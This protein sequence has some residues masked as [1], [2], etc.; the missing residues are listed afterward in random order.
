MCQGQAAAKRWRGDGSR[1]APTGRM[2][3]PYQER[4]GPEADIVSRQRLGLGGGA[5]DWNA[6]TDTLQACGTLRPRI[7]L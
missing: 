1:L 5:R 2:A 7:H 6:L 4:P 3:T